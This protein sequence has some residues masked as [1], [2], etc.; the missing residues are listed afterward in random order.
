MSKSLSWSLEAERHE[1]WHARDVWQI[2]SNHW[3]IQCILAGNNV[4][5][6][7][8]SCSVSVNPFASTAAGGKIL[9]GGNIGMWTIEVFLESVLPKLLSIEE[10]THCPSSRMVINIMFF[11]AVEI[12]WILL[13]TRVIAFSFSSFSLHLF[14]F[15][16]CFVWVAQ[17]SA[18][19]RYR[20][21]KTP[22]MTG[23]LVQ[24]RPQIWTENK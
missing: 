13:C 19:R 24:R 12:R 5:S 15:S 7:H 6:W 4:A 18:P 22:E 16:L 1:C 9:F 20:A 8:L 2:S 14:I 21:T 10:D 11:F 17:S 3:W 23:M